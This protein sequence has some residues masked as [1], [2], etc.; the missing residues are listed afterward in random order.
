MRLRLTAILML[1]AAATSAQ[2]GD[3][4]SEGDAPEEA[5]SAMVQ[6]IGP[7]LLYTRE[8]TDAELAQKVRTQLESLGSIS[9]GF[10]DR[11]RVLNAVQMPSDPAW[12][13]E[14]PSYAYATRET[15]D[16]LGLT[17]RAV[18]RQ[19]PDSAPAR[20][21]HMGAKEG[22]FLRPH[23]S[24][25]SG[26]DADIGFFYKGDRFPARGAP[27]E[28]LMDPARNWAM[29][30]TLITDT[31][32]QLILVDRG[33]QR[34][35][36]SY[37]LSIGENPIWLSQIF[38]RLIVHARSHR[39][40]FH[41]RFYSPRSQELGRRIQPLLAL[42][43][44]QNRTVHVVQAGNTLG[45]IAARYKTTVAAVRKANHMKAR[46]LLQLGQNLVI[47]LRGACTS[48]PLP[49][50]MAVPPRLVP[51]EPLPSPAESRGGINPEMATAE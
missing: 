31:D 39:D 8:I 43:P 36:K 18:R 48:C 2:E 24:H 10:A 20:L 34:V 9:I 40:H 47:P 28:R 19:F 44:D 3:T 32:V 41:A 49:P 17:F 1:A 7:G 12:I 45:L 15:V 13:V 33:I 21:S 29:L 51:P 14:R 46:S 4:T 16:A 22:G 38:G 35:L 50:P 42:R 5:E 27:R 37:A 6:P 26:R 11:G 23:R 25:Q 30:R